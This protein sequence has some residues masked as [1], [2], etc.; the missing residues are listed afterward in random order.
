MQ[1]EQVRA[2]GAGV[3]GVAP[4]ADMLGRVGVAAKRRLAAG[5]AAGGATGGGGGR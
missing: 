1:R 3:K 5:W 4:A 2:G